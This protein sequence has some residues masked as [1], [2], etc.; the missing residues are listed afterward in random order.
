MEFE[1]INGY[2]ERQASDIAGKHAQTATITMTILDIG[3]M[4]LTYT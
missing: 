3:N 4:A 1:I 2:F